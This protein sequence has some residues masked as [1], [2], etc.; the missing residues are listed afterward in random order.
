[1]GIRIISGGGQN[2]GGSYNSRKSSG[3]SSSRSSSGPGGSSSSS[4]PE[5]ALSGDKPRTR[6][7]VISTAKDLGILDSEGRI[8]RGKNSE[9]RQLYK[10]YKSGKDIEALTDK[11]MGVP[12]TQAPGSDE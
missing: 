11:G 2:L 9:W 4:D 1:M 10:E 7:E 8:K 3:S 12:V 6:S 5:N